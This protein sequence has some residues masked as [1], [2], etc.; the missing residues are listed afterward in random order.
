MTLPV[1]DL[2]CAYM[3]ILNA[4]CFGKVLDLFSQ[5]VAGGQYD[6]SRK[7]IDHI[8]IPNLADLARDE[9][10]GHFISRLVVL[11]REPRLTEVRW[12]RLADQ[13]TTELYGEEFFER[14]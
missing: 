10:M 2:L 1:H 6:L 11:G 14:I 3:G 9:R 8:P 5:H 4:P 12:N 7:Y 13:F